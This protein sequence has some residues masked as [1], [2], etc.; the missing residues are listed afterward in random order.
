LFLIAHFHNTII[1][2]AV[3]GFFAGF[4]YWFPKAMGFKLNERLGKCAFWC[5]I[6]GFYLA[7]MP[8]YFLGFM[9]MT[10]RLSHYDASTGWHPYLVVAMVGMLVVMIGI[11]FQLAQIV[12][13]FIK[14]EAYRDVTGDPW[15]G[16]TLEWSI[17]SPPPVYNFAIVPHVHDR[18]AYWQQKQAK[19]APKAPVYED[20]HMPRNSAVPIVLAFFSFLV[21]F[22]LIWYIFWMVAVGFVGMLVCT[23][24]R[25]FTTNRDYYIKAAEVA[26]IEAALA[27]ARG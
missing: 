27:K 10:R 23:L 7:F 16:R 6:V 21:G 8:L 26:S 17:P 20:I 24:A 9:G 12:V 3:F 4:S 2:G 19:H 5:W 25:A 18:D 22:G 1:G 11:I 15:N 14:R 13:S